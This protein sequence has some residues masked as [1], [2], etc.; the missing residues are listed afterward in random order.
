MRRGSAPLPLALAVAGVGARSPL[1]VRW[2]P[3]RERFYGNCIS[4]TRSRRTVN[5]LERR[6]A[7]LKI[8]SQLSSD[9]ELASIE[10]M[11]Y[12]GR[13][14]MA[15]R[16]RAPA[17]HLHTI[18]SAEESLRMMRACQSARPMLL[19]LRDS[20]GGTGEPSP[21]SASSPSLFAACA[22]LAGARGSRVETP[23]VAVWG[24]RN[25]NKNL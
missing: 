10:R 25:E 15:A 19:L 3:W 4:C 20:Q 18:E 11:E 22:S 5:A 12:S 6:H 8:E 23:R 21:A 14:L 9:E 17:A 13:R 7:S 24:H 2:L 16:A 1:A